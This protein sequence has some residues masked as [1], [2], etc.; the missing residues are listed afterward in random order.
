MI[1]G[2]LLLLGGMIYGG[3]YLMTKAA[4]NRKGGKYAL[5]AELQAREDAKLAR[6]KA[7]K[8]A[9]LDEEAQQRSSAVAALEAAFG[10]RKAAEQIMVELEA[11]KAEWER[12]TSDADSNND[13]KD[14][15]AFWTAELE[16]RSISNNILKHWLGGRSATFITTALWGNRSADA[17]RGK[18]AEFLRGGGYSGTGSGFF[19][20]EDGWMLTNHHVVGESVEVDVRPEDGQIRKAKVVKVDKDADLAL[21]KVEMKPRTWLPLAAS[22]AAMGTSVFTI[23]FP[24]ANVQGV[25]PKFTDG[26]VSSLSGIRDD[27]LRYQVSVPVQP[28]N[29]GGPLVDMKSGHVVGVIEARL[30]PDLNAENVNYAVK[31]SSIATLLNGTTTS[32]P[33]A[34]SSPASP[35]EAEA[36]SRARS[37]VSLILVK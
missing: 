37:A 25:E 23:G 9:E 18:V 2:V 36:I 20:S 14:L 22:D 8:Q 3:L 35:S 13:P 19:V 11:I 1:G 32:I 17:G 5:S 6:Q 26:R 29:S 33:A 31:G 27:S 28:G 12:L 7:E 16:K 4:E 30:S 15:Y 34:G 21:L 10:D 24:N